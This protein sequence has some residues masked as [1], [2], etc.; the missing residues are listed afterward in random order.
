MARPVQYFR[1][2]A[3]YV[4][5]G[6]ADT[7]QQVNLGPISTGYTVT[8]LR[9][10]W[11]AQHVVELAAS[12]AVGVAIHVGMILLPATTDPGAVPNAY[13]NPDADWLSYEV[14]FFTPYRVEN[15]DG[16]TFELDIAPGLDY[17]RDD[18]GM[19]L[20]LEDSIL[21]LS[22]AVDPAYDAQARFYFSFGGSLLLTLP[23]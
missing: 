21:W 4:N 20:A 13:L 10:R 14:D 3:N 22:A 23:A 1:G 7:S 5:G 11:Q 9:W 16:T 8:R 19:R 18:K 6:V 2:S 12:E 15:P 17:E